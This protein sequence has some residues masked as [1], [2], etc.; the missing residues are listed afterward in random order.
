[1]NNFCNVIIQQ[2][3]GSF[4]DGGIGEVELRLVSPDRT[5]VPKFLQVRKVSSRFAYFLSD[6]SLFATEP[7]TTNRLPPEPLNP[8]TVECG[9]FAVAAKCGRSI[10][11][12]MA[13][14]C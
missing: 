5:A 2:A 3:R 14:Y 7:E 1:M 8:D 11:K 12:T 13:R 10:C 9:R 6:T 4:R